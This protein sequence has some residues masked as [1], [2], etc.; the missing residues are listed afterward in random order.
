MS[1]RDPWSINQSL[2]PISESDLIE[3]ETKLGVSFPEDYKQ[4]LLTYNGG[5]P[6]PQRVK[7]PNT[8]HTV[9]LDFFYGIMKVPDCRDLTYAYRI[10]KDDLPEGVIP[11][12][13]DPGGNPF[14]LWTVGDQRGYVYFWDRRSFFSESIDSTDVYYLAESF[15]SLLAS[16]CD[17]D[18]SEED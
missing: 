7:I 17:T 1:D 5:I 13:H 12:G 4:F 18:Y 16:L 9:L 8:N 6:Y 2:P 14:F 3:C 11:I 15:T 10:S